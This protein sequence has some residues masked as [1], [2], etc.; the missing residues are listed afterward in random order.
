MEFRI[1]VKGE[2]VLL[3]F[4]GEGVIWSFVLSLSMLD[5]ESGVF[6]GN[7]ECIGLIDK[8]C[9]FVV[10][11]DIFNWDG[12]EGICFIDFDWVFLLEIW[13]VIRFFFLLVCWERDLVF[14]SWVILFCVFCIN[15]W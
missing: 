2:I 4:F 8:N 10:E 12:R 9:G 14:K 5:S 6:W 13:L 1:F 7:I 11:K 15:L 3:L